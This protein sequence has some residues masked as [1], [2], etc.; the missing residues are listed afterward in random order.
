MI[1][2]EDMAILIS[3]QGFIKRFPVSGY[4]KQGR[5]GRE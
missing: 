3:H 2:Q 5:G 4:R 1:A